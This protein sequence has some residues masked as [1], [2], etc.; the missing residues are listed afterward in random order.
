MRRKTNHL[1]HGGFTLI[2][3]IVSLTAASFLMVGLS[4]TLF[5]AFRA[6]DTSNTPATNTLEGLARLSD[7][8]AE[9]PYTQTVI[10]KTANAITVTVPDRNDPDTNPETIRYAW[11]GAAA[12]PLTRQY[13][14]GIVANVVENVHN[15]GVKYYQPA[16]VVKYITISIQVASESQTRV[17]TSIPLLNQ[18]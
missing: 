13:N 4:S 8:A 11:S 12:D 5:I 18:P 16:A 10:E 9:L 3:L 15:F 2:E 7:M 17:E 14:G 6:T 1:T